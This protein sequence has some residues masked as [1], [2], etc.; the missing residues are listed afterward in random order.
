[1]IDQETIQKLQFDKMIHEVAKYAIG[2]YTKERIRA[3]EISTRLAIVKIKQKETLEARLIIDSGQYV[4]FMGLTQIKRLMDEVQKGLLLMPRE[5]IEAADFLRSNRLIRIFFEKNQY[6]APLLY[7]YSRSLSEFSVVE[8]TIYQKIQNGRIAEDA[9]KELRRIRKKQRECEKEIEEK[10]LKFLH[11]PNNRSLV[12]ETLIVKKEEH[13]TIPI[14]A[15]YKNKVA[16]RI[17]AQSNNGQTVF[18]EPAAVEKLNERLMMLRTEETAEEYQ[19]LAELN[20]LLSER[21]LA[22]TNG[23]EAITALDI[24]F[25]RAKFGRELGGITPQINKEERIVIVQGKHPLLPLDAVPLDF[26]LG[27]SYRGLV[28]TGANAGGKTVVLKTIGLLT[29]MTMFGLQIPAKSG[30]DIAVLDHLFVDIGDQQ[31]IENALSTFSGHMK[32]IA[33]ILQRIE[34]HTLVLLDEIGSGTEP[35][36]GAGLAI[37]IMETMY[38][39]GAILVATTHYGEIKRFAAEHADFIPAAMA[40]DQE[41]L[42]P[43][44]RLQVGQIGDSQALWIARKM[45]MAPELLQQAAAFINEKQYPTQ[46]KMFKLAKKEAAIFDKKVNEHARYHKGDRIFLNESKES[47]IVFEDQGKPDIQVFVNDEILEVPRRRVRFEASVHELYPLNYDLDS[48]FTDFQTRKQARDLARGSKKAH[49]RLAKEAEA[50][51]QHL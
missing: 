15:S 27:K 29:L 10:L 41:T 45:K 40:F 16:G 31:N 28:I 11:H 6:Q 43:K 48:L 32:N 25:A 12:Q 19:I 34:R 7:D 18:I 33:A 20:G 47:A 42:T 36:E 9:S 21:A 24:I 2:D 37:A 1:M 23:I 17:V 44:Y 38:Q 13:F 22:I 50:R 3:L 5:L 39:S 30:T 14:K 4:P 46:K 51:K 35:N 49:K 26:T 8:E